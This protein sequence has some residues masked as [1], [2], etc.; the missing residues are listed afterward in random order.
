MTCE[1]NVWT[2]FILF[3]DGL[4]DFMALVRAAKQQLLGR[5]VTHREVSVPS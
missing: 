2:L 1:R 4:V 5:K 3:R